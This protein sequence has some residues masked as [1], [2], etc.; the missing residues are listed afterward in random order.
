MRTGTVNRVLLA[1]AG[2]L[3]LALGGVVLAAGLGAPFPRW[4]VHSS[5][6][7][8]LLSRAERTSFRDTGWWWPA[9]IAGLAILFLIGVW[10][11]VSVLR[12]HRVAE[13]R[14]DTGDGGTARLRGSALQNALSRDASGQEGM[15]QSDVLLT[16]RRGAPAVRAWFRLE[17]DMP[18]GAALAEFTSGPLARAR[19]SA[20]L[21]ALPAE[22][23]LRVIRHRAGR[24]T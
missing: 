17:P 10:W 2:L 5:A 1:V 4:W 23:R 21:A 3:L 14:V 11:L 18:P 8:V 6:H 20:G 13:V 9:L 24:V 19:D 12:R 15:A 7:D 16:G 22:V